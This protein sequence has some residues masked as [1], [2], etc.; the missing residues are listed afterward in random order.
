[1]HNPP[2][3]LCLDVGRWLA[4]SDDLKSYASGRVA[5]GRI[6]LAGKVEAEEPDE[7]NGNATGHQHIHVKKYKENARG[8]F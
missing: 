2:Y 5:T 6:C 3:P 1:M 4:C 8:K 7:I